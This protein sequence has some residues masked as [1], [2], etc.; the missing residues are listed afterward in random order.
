[1]SPTWLIGSLDLVIMA[2]LAHASWTDWRERRI[3]NRTCLAVAA[4]A[5]ALAAFE[6][7]LIGS[8][9]TG[10]SVLVLGVLAWRARLAGGGDVKLL[11]ATAIWA[12][13]AGLLPLVLG[14]GLAGG[15]LAIVAVLRAT[16]ALALVSPTMM[17][18]SAR[19]AGTVPYGVAICAGAAWVWLAT[20][21]A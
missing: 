15:A 1:M 3:G 9:I 20:P 21:L 18:A 16:P 14:T 19:R 17:L 13:P 8:I 5:A 6:Q 12:G 7:Q 10:A 2:L 4:A 11:A